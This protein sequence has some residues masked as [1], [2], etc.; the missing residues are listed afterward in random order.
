MKKLTASQYKKN[1]YI[2]YRPLVADDNLDYV[3][4][5]LG[6][7]EGAYKAETN[8]VMKLKN[9]V[10]PAT[11][12]DNYNYYL[13]ELD[14]SN[15]YNSFEF[16]N[17]Y[18]VPIDDN[19]QKLELA[20]TNNTYNVNVSAAVETKYW[21]SNETLTS[22]GAPI[23]RFC[24]NEYINT[25]KQFNIDAFKIVYNDSTEPVF[26]SFIGKGLSL[27][28]PSENVAVQIVHGEDITKLI[29]L[30]EYCLKI[31]NGDENLATIRYNE[32]VNNKC[33]YWTLKENDK[34]F[35]VDGK[36]AFYDNSGLDDYTSY[37]MVPLKEDGSE[38][39]RIY[40]DSES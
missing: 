23:E 34:Y 13:S 30:K 37:I 19:G 24:F 32:Y 29:N 36:Y 14:Y 4:E 31:T 15:I 11:S 40:I 1:D 9:I 21:F 27:A 26:Y 8:V 22:G 2:L 17:W 39:L 10:E 5:N 3:L 33:W 28:C 6:S 18:L 16:M 12:K 35:S 38:D 25:A 7:A 20:Y